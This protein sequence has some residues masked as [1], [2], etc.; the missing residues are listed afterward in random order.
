LPILIV[1]ESA[2]F[3]KMNNNLDTL[4]FTYMNVSYSIQVKLL[5]HSVNFLAYDIKLMYA[6]YILIK[7]YNAWYFVADLQPCR[8]LK[9]VIIKTVEKHIAIKRRVLISWQNHN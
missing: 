8:K 1:S 4:T 3:I 9:D 7:E 2:Y 5:Q 6:R